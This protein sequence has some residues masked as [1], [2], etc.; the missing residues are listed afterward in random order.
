[1]DECPSSD[2]DPR[3][4]A[5]TFLSGSHDHPSLE[6]ASVPWAHSRVWN[7]QAAATE[8]EWK[9][10]GPSR[11]PAR[12]PLTAHV[13]QRQGRRGTESCLEFYQSSNITNL[14]V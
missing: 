3:Q 2:Q 4:L 1:M 10:A 6:A 12:L 9:E 8:T 14:K 7:G 5:S 11:H 13:T